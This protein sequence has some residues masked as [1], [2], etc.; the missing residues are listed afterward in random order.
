MVFQLLIHR[1]VA[2]SSSHI[3]AKYFLL[4]WVKFGII[5]FL[6]EEQKLFF[7]VSKFQFWIISNSRIQTI[8]FTLCFSRINILI[9]LKVIFIL[10]NHWIISFEKGIIKPFLKI[11]FSLWLFLL[12]LDLFIKLNPLNFSFELF[13]IE[14]FI[15][16]AFFH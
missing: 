16:R 1:Y 4:E 5:N 7:Q 2:E 12:C 9:I 10:L 14:T 13:Q 8:Y 15:D 3:V 11:L 6:K